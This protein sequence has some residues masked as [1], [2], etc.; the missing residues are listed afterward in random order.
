M[1]EIC[2]SDPSNEEY[3]K[4]SR[5]NLLQM[6]DVLYRG[7]FVE[8]T[9]D[10]FPEREVPLS[11]QVRAR[12]NVSFELGSDAYLTDSDDDSEATGG[13]AQ[14]RPET[15]SETATELG[16]NGTLENDDSDG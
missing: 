15:I 8:P 13:E 16:D 2:E 12:R 14:A 3:R 4:Y 11:V 7:N 9:V 6:Y 5:Q 10:D 1:W